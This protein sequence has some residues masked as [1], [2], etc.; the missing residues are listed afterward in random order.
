MANEVV[1]VS[2]PADVVRDIDRTEGDRSRFLEE[3][4]RH[5]LKRRRRV[6]LRQSLRNPHAETGEIAEAGLGD[7]AASLPDEDAT[8]LVDLE[9]GVEVRWRPGEG[10]TQAEH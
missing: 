4:A 9:A 2:L 1:T 3:A 7:W 10:W 8:G 5:E 6:W